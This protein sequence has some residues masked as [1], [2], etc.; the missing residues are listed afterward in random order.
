[1]VDWDRFA[2]KQIHLGSFTEE[3]IDFSSFYVIFA[4][5]Y[6]SLYSDEAHGLNLL[7]CFSEARYEI[8]E[9]LEINL[10]VAIFVGDVYSLHDFLGVQILV[11]LGGNFNETFNWQLVFKTVKVTQLLV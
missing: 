9:L 8:E 7:L 10:T 5:S 4:L 2:C 1:M 6:K 11:L 3:L